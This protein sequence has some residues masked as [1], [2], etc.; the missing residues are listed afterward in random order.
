MRVIKKDY[1]CDGC[2]C[3]FNW[4]VG[5]CWFGSRKEMEENPEKIKYYLFNK[6]R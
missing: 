3:F 2:G 4:G 6:M 1:I 5:R